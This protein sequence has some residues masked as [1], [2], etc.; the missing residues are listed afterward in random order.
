[1]KKKD[2]EDLLGYHINLKNACM[3]RMFPNGRNLNIKESVALNQLGKML[4]TIEHILKMVVNKKESRAKR[5]KVVGM[6]TSFRIKLD[7]EILG[8]FH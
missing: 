7:K 4:E 2:K 3:I 6:M 1:M 8:Y 5:K